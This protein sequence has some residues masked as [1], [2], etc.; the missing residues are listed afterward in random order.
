MEGIWPFFAAQWSEDKELLIKLLN[1]FAEELPTLI[2]KIHVPIDQLSTMTH[3]FMKF[4]VFAS[5]RKK[6]WLKIGLTR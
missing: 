3:N 6:Y 4:T 2:A 1:C 5:W